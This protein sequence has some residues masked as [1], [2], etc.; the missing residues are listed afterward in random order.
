MGEGSRRRRIGYPEACIGRLGSGVE[1]WR[2]GALSRADGRSR[3]PRNRPR[4]PYW[5][6]RLACRLEPVFW[7]DSAPR[8]LDPLLQPSPTRRLEDQTRA[9]CAKSLLAANAKT[10]PCCSTYGAA[11]R[12]EGVPDHRRE[13]TVSSL[14]SDSAATKTGH[15]RRCRFRETPNSTSKQYSKAA[16]KQ[17][18]GKSNNGQQQ[19]ERP[20]PRLGLRVHDQALVHGHAPPSAVAAAPGLPLVD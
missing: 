5:W 9:L 6:L 7:C 12:F 8:T 14:L 13:L 11:L 2:L 15:T 3:P 20:D 4:C 19:R 10:E 17:S 18:V 16:F 1:V